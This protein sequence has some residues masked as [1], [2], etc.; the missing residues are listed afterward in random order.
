MTSLLLTNVFEKRNLV[1]RAGHE[2][3]GNKL[4]SDAVVEIHKVAVCIHNTDIKDYVRLCI[5]V[6]KDMPKHEPT[7]LNV[8]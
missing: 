1:G 5:D 4:L 7:G 3:T 6:L 2:E 8:G